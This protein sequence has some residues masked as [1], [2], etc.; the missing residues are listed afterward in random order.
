MYCISSF[1]ENMDHEFPAHKQIIVPRS[2]YKVDGEGIKKKCRFNTLKSVDYYEI[3]DKHGFLYVEF[4][5]LLR[6]DS[7]LQER[8]DRIKA[9][10]LAK[11]DK[12]KFREDCFKEIHKELVH[13]FKDSV[14][15][16][17]MMKDKIQNIP[18]HFDTNGKYIIVVAPLNPD[19]QKDKVIEILKFLETLKDKVAQGI[20]KELYSSV[21]I[22]PLDKFCS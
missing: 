15:I 2:G 16:R 9:S 14:M 22:M 7:Q 12:K 20:P 11:S 6:Q 21:K 1:L 19:L 4:S 8:A 10:N 13:K 17:I 5:D 18:K 3:H